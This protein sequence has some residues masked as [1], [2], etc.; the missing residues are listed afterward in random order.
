M[1]R[2]EECRC[3]WAEIPFCVLPQTHASTTCRFMTFQRK[4]QAKTSASRRVLRCLFVWAGRHGDCQR[5][6]INKQTA[7]LSFRARSDP[8]CEI[9]S[10]NVRNFNF[11]WIT[12][13]GKKKIFRFHCCNLKQKLYEKGNHAK[14]W[15]EIFLRM[16]MSQ[17]LFVLYLGN[18]HPLTTLTSYF[19]IF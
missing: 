13:P 4:A 15:F 19:R 17:N 16:G 12:P 5:S 10:P 1:K 11:R 9:N 14:P 18:K 6:G 2:C 7:E 8:I 3:Q